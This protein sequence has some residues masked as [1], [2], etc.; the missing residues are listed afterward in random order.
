MRMLAF[1]TGQIAAPEGEA[2]RR[3]SFVH[4]ARP[5]VDAA[6]PQRLRLRA[7]ANAFE[8]FLVRRADQGPVRSPPVVIESHAD[9]A[10]VLGAAGQEEIARSGRGFGIDDQSPTDP[11]RAADLQLRRPGGGTE[12]DQVRDNAVRGRAD[13]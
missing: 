1:V 6:P 9:K 5:G 3:G 11:A 7:E 10:E 12:L 4:D 8:R 13:V 2:L